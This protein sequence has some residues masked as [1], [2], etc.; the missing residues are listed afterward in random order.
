MI[1]DRPK[2]PADMSEIRLIGTCYSCVRDECLQPKQAK[3]NPQHGCRE[4][5]TNGE[6]IEEV[7]EHWDCP[8]CGEILF[9]ET[10]D[11]HHCREAA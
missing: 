8:E 6:S 3:D 4:G 2:P 11:Q 5:W 9:I 7:D 1:R 10:A